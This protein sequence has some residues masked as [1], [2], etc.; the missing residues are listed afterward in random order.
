MPEGR[1]S[2][3]KFFP[4][5]GVALSVTFGEPI[6]ADEIRRRLWVAGERS[7]V[8]SLTADNEPTVGDPAQEER[9]VA[10]AGKRWL[11]D[12]LQHRMHESGEGSTQQRVARLRSEI[13]A[14]LQEEVEA[15]GRRVLDGKA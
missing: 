14:V 3:Y 4:R 13:T 8:S 2:P 9:S 12:I 1:K 15:L 11:G 10:T 6:P 5:R 7:G